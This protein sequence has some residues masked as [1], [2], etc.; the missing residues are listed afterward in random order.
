MKQTVEEAAKEY[1]KSVRYPGAPNYGDYTSGNKPVGSF[2]HAFRAGAE[3]RIN[4][5]WH[6][7]KYEQP[8]CEKHAVTDEWIDFIAKDE[9]DLKR[10]VK[11]YGNGKWAYVDDLLPDTFDEILEAN[12]DVLERIKEKGD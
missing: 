2:N 12:M 3:W 7:W 9:K 8:E 5:A 10:I 4:S 11:S 1:A 6:D